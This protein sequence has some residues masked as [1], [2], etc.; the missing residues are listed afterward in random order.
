MDTSTSPTE[1]DAPRWCDSQKKQSRTDCTIRTLY[2]AYATL[3]T[4]CL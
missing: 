1:D 2:L 4:N 3:N